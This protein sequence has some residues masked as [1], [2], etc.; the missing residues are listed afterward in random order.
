MYLKSLSLRGF[1]SF[2]DSS[3]IEFAPG[4]NVV[5]GPNGS[6]KSNIVDAISWVLGTQ[7]PKALRSAKMEDVIFAGGQSRGAAKSSKVTIVLDNAE[8]R[9]SLELAEVAITRHLSRS[10][11]SGYELNGR[12]CRLIDLSELL[13]DASIGRGQHTIISQGNLD[14]ILDAKASDRRLTIEDASGIAKYRRRQDRTARR[15]GV[16]EEESA[17]AQELLRDINRRIKP[18]E[19]QAK[20]AKRHIDLGDEIAQL[21][22][23]ILGSQYREHLSLSQGGDEA[24]AVLKEKI[25]SL[26]ALVFTYRQRLQ[27]LEAK[28]LL[29][30]DSKLID[31]MRRLDALLARGSLTL[32]LGRER[33]KQNLARIALLSNRSGIIALEEKSKALTLTKEELHAS[34]LRMGPELD[35]LEEKEAELKKRSSLVNMESVATLESKEREISSAQR[36]LFAK[37]SELTSEL[38]ATK[39]EFDSASRAIE[40]MDSQGTKTTSRLGELDSAILA[41]SE[42][43]ERAKLRLEEIVPVLSALDQEI[44][45]REGSLSLL[46]EAGAEANAIWSTLESALSKLHSKS[47]LE[48][49]ST[50]DTPIGVV[51][52]LIEV[53]EGYGEVVEAA[54]GSYGLGVV[55][56]NRQKGVLGFQKIKEYSD[57]ALIVAGFEGA[58]WQSLSFRELPRL[59]SIGSLILDVHPAIAAIVARWIGD[60]YLF[61][62]SMDEA[63]EIVK[64][65]PEI[66]LVTSNRDRVTSFGFE[67]PENAAVVS[68]RA[69]NEA[70]DRKDQLRSEVSTLTG[71]VS[72][73]KTK[74]RGISEE[75]SSNQAV[76]R[77]S[78]MEI[79]RLRGERNRIND[80]K[81]RFDQDQEAS[82]HSLARALIRIDE[83]NLALV[84][85]AEELKAVEEEFGMV[86]G[87]LDDHR[88]ELANLSR[89]RAALRQLR[90]QLEVKLARLGERLAGVDAE[91][92][93]NEIE[94]IQMQEKYASDEIE[95]K[96][97]NRYEIG[98]QGVITEVLRIESLV[99]TIST[100]TSRELDEVNISK[101]Q[102][103][104]EI[105]MLRSEIE[106][107]SFER[108]TASEELVALHDSIREAS[109]RSAVVS[110]RI[111][112]ELEIAPEIAMQI[113]I[114]AGIEPT[115]AASTLQARQDELV[116]L[117]PINQL[118]KVEL[119]ELYE[120]HKFITDQLADINSSRSELRSISRQIDKEMKEVFLSA[121][122]DIDNNFRETFELLFPGGRGSLVLTD[123]DN[124]L[125]AGLEFDISIPG[126]TLRRLPLLSGGERS[127]VALGFLFAVFR[128]RPS[129]FY[130][131]D[132]VEAALD[133]LNLSRLLVLLES[134]GSHAQLIVISHQKRTMEIANR[135]IGVSMAESGSSKVVIENLK[136][137]QL[138]LSSQ[139]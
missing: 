51:T 83:L 95:V 10:G 103:S 118:A 113:P 53:K 94:I 137:R 91:L 33:E 93:R 79:E 73:L 52:E 116:S 55:A 105:S 68:R 133:D 136:A 120:R 107:L 130:V 125:E 45:A 139:D 77:R 100:D 43:L 65:H 104:K 82:R 115:Q 20:A 19:R 23:Y 90:S 12:D 4:I 50:V 18:L 13:L 81:G 49:A 26:G 89:S 112:R 35:D 78:S 119:E 5:V 38:N 1:K 138:T 66:T 134:F 54:L 129:P 72:L 106:R 6:G 24:E 21:K 70:R 69:I 41:S 7:T 61:E 111:W 135:L 28:A 86:R 58:Q 98:Y 99:K 32:A 62:G 47:Q 132:E 48:T 117:G 9:L 74:R 131:L 59:V 42:L 60:I 127:L 97:L 31:E 114:L 30:D 88:V 8:R 16:V 2:A 92:A 75:V 14:V 126:K 63:E 109:I 122:R 56:S 67:A 80:A 85:I 15:L 34:I 102:L 123:Q 36:S 101:A 3:T 108:S 22:A 25:D 64:A 44:D 39:R 57:R 124:P 96:R 11:E 128:S 87:D 46:R 40:T 84:P 71:E 121:Y 17:R 76:V 110:E 29:I 37:K 27:E